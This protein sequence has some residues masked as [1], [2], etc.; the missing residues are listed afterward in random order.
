MRCSVLRTD[1]IE[2]RSVF[3]THHIYVDLLAALCL[4]PECR[5][6][7]TFLPKVYEPGCGNS[8]AGVGDSTTPPLVWHF[9][10]ARRRSRE[11]IFRDINAD[12]ALH[13]SPDG[14]KCVNLRTAC[15][16][17]LFHTGGDGQSGRKHF[18]VCEPISPW[19]RVGLAAVDFRRPASVH[20]P[21][22]RRPEQR[23]HHD[24]GETWLSCPRYAAI[25]RLHRNP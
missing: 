10:Y 19:M 16:D 2:G 15:L 11:A 1:F 7:R 8:R 24:G 18:A 13:R 20:C 23:P 3:R 17:L 9:E 5:V 14:P 22:P 4:H 12:E 25:C 6:S 21:E